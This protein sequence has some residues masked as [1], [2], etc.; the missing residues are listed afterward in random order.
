MSER[1]RRRKAGGS[2][3]VTAGVKPAARIEGGSREE[4]I[5]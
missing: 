3:S 1:D 2:P 5:E 4:A